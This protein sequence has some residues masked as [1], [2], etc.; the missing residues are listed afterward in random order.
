MR[1]LM[2]ILVFALS[3]SARCVKRTNASKL[4]PELGKQAAKQQGSQ[5]SPGRSLSGTDDFGT[6]NTLTPVGSQ[7]QV[8]QSNGQTQDGQSNGQQAGDSTSSS[9]SSTAA[10]A[11]EQTTSPSSS[12]S[13][14]S[15]STTPTP[16]PSAGDSSSSDTGSTSSSGSS[17]T[18]NTQTTQTTGGGGGSGK[19]G[20]MKGVCFNSG[21]KP[22]MYDEMT[23]A[24]DWITFGMDIPGGPGSSRAQQDHIP[25]MAFAKH[26]PDAVKLVNGP[27]P[28]EWLLTFNEPDFSYN[29]VTPK[30]TGKEAADAIKDLLAKP[31]SKTKFVAPA[32]ADPNHPFLEEFFAE[33]KC[34]DFFS[35]YNMH[36]Y[37]PSSAQ[38]IS[39]IKSYHGKWNDKPL[40]ITEVAPGGANCAMGPND[41][42]KFMKDIY[43]FAKGSGFVDKVFWN[44]GNQ[45]DASDHNVC[46]SWLVDASGKPGPLL[47]I[48]ES[49]D[50]S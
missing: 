30:M 48:F 38:I 16:S 43:G 8:G 32:T 18:S 13:S 34:K 5:A 27:N 15:S 9:S 11:S 19:C 20:S 1:S 33:C 26:V 24:S 36:Q 21:M 23:T 28:P 50:C 47:P 46:N 17:E 29:G 41:V 3:V 7:D 44:T 49:I 22:S 37:N 4:T 42:G 6:N 10:G 25:M 39:N 40:W 45:I 2:L 12:S 31:G 14:S 35:A